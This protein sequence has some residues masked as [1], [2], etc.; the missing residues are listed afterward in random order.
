MFRMFKEDK[1]ATFVLEGG[2]EGMKKNEI[3]QKYEL[4]EKQYDAATKRI[5]VKQ[6]GPRN[7]GDGAEKH[8]R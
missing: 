2:S 6:W 1:E 7:G 5:R 4:T 3:M 8:G